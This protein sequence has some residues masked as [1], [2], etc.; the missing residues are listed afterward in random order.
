MAHLCRLTR[1]GDKGRSVIVGVLSCARTNLPYLPTDRA[2]RCA[3][4]LYGVPK[5]LLTRLCGSFNK[6]LLRK[7]IHSFLRAGNGIG[8][9][10]H[11][12]V[13][14]TPS[15]FFTC[16]GNVTTATSSVRVAAFGNDLCVAR[17]ASLRVM[18]NNRA[19]TSL[20]VT[21]LGSGHSNSRRGLG[22]VFIPVGLSIIS[23]RG[24]RRLVP[25]VSEFTGDR[26]GMDRTSL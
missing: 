26:G 9:N 14:G 13:L 10:V 6:E 20:T 19:A 22:Q 7:G 24:T 23:P 21:L 15:V 12:A 18:G 16:G 8:G 11:G 1:S 4:C 5:V 2:S 3:T 17:V 25:G